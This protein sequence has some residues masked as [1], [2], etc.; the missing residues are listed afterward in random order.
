MR[1]VFRLPGGGEFHPNLQLNRDLRQQHVL[2]DELRSLAELASLGAREIAVREA[3][4]TGDYYGSIHGGLGTNRKG[5]T[6]GRVS[7]DDHKAHWVEFGW[8]TTSGRQVPGKNVLRRGARRAGLSVRARK[9]I[10]AE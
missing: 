10:G 7:A 6:V 1:S 9:R 2:D 4:D 3:F 8:R 5:L